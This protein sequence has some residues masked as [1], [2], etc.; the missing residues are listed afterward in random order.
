[1]ET[2]VALGLFV[3]LGTFKFPMV[4]WHEFL[5]VTQLTLKDPLVGDINCLFQL[6][7]E[8]LPSAKRLWFLD[9]GCSRHVTGDAFML[10][11]L[12]DKESGHVMYGEN[13]KGKTRDEFIMGSPSI[14]TIK[15]VLL[16]KRL[17]HNL[18]S[19]SQ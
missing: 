17:K 7:Q 18:L 11:K 1:M 8:I 4:K 10:I 14:I 15:N 12:D 6:L 2:R 19:I 16:V 13:M 3:M 5:N 9:N